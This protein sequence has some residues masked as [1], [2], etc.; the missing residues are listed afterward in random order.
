MKNHQTKEI[1]KK[2]KEKVVQTIN[3]IILR[4]YQLLFLH[5]PENSK[6]HQ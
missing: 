3:K 5:R 2:S 1:P 4:N 6:N